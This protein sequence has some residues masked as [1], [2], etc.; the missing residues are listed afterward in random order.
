MP[1]LL[2]IWTSKVRN[3]ERV[4]IIAILIG[5]LVIFAAWWLAAKIVIKEVE[6]VYY[7][8]VNNLQIQDYS[9]NGKIVEMNLPTIKFEVGQVVVT[10]E[11]NVLTYETY[12]AIIDDNTQYYKRTEEQTFATGKIEDLTPGSVIT[13]YT[14][15]NP[16]QTE[17]FT[18]TKVEV[19]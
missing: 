12:S 7:N 5:M 11:G 4:S 10:D 1:N 6:E 18:A 3:F 2:K 13:V 16:Y 15:Q 9:L 8:N 17:S 14:K 19:N